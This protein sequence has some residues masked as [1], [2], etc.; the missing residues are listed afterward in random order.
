MLTKCVVSVL[1]FPAFSFFLFLC[2]DIQRNK[3]DEV[4]IAKLNECKSILDFSNPRAQFREKEIKRRHLVDISEYVSSEKG[5][6][7]AQTYGAFMDMIGT[8]IVRALP[9]NAPMDLVVEAEDDEPFYEPSWPH[10]QLVYELLRK[11]VMSSVTDNPGAR[12]VITVPFV[13]GLVEMFQTEDPRERDY[14]KTILHRV[15]GKM[16]PLRVHIRHAMVDMFHR[17]VY[18][19]ERSHGLSEL[20][21]IL[22]SIIHGFAIPLKEEHRDLLMTGLLPLHLP[23][24]LPS[25]HD[26]LSFCVGQYAEKEHVLGREILKSILRHWPMRSSRKEVLLLMEMEEI[27]E[28]MGEDEVECMIP[29]VFNRLGR[30]IESPQFQVAER[31]LFYWNNDIIM[32]MFSAYREALMAAVVG[33][34]LNNTKSHWNRNVLLLSENVVLT[35]KEL[36]ADLFEDARIAYEQRKK[37]GKRRDAER[38]VRWQVVYKMARDRNTSSN[39]KSLNMRENLV[40]L[41]HHLTDAV[42]EDQSDADSPNPCRQKQNM[43]RCEQEVTQMIAD[44]KGK[45]TNG[46]NH[47]E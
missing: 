15:Y 37:D 27:L 28:V 10:L 14:L 32:D 20:L 31:A 1:F 47:E 6:L 8:N 18:E 23:A 11:F 36:D 39:Q 22:G 35:L 33:P 44:A 34:L 46:V 17:V 5:A 41:M 40:P 16:M 30:C 12:A 43:H 42:S 45:P 26:Q 29:M 21:E 2:V 38:L 13:T 7:N 4:F 3:R 9:H 25:Y 24:S 19:N